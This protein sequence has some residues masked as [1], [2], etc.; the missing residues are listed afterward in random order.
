MA[1]NYR[2]ESSPKADADL[3]R[4]YQYI[5]WASQDQGI[6]SAFIARIKNAI[7]SAAFLPRSF[8]RFLDD[9]LF[10]REVRKIVFGSYI[11][12]FIIDEVTKTVYIVRIL[13]GKM[14]YHRYL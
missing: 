8:S 3:D 12:P 11:I 9:G 4:I 10:E 7:K 1:E 6:A 13:H 2:I 14:D 5:F